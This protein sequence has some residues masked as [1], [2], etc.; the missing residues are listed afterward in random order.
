[1]AVAS[2]TSGTDAE[3]REREDFGRIVVSTVAFLAG[4]APVVLLGFN[5][6]G[7][8]VEVLAGYGV[9]LWWVLAVGFGT[10]ALPRPAPTTGGWL[11]LLS[12]LGLAAFGALSLT[13]SA[14]PERGLTE[15]SRMVVAG[16]SVLLGMSA[17]RAG[18]A[19]SLAGGVLAGLGVIVTAAVLARLQPDLFPGANQTAEFLGSDKR[20]SWPLNYW[21]ALGACAAVTISLAVPLA[22]R[23]RSVVGSALAVAPIPLAALLLVFALSRGGIVAAVLGLASAVLLVSPRPVL[24]RTMIAP[25]IGSVAVLLAATRRDPLMDAVGGSAQESAGSEVLT[26]AIVAVLG[27]AAVQAAFRLADNARWTPSIPRSS[28]RVGGRIIAGLVVLA[29]VVGLAAG[30]P[31]RVDDAWQEFKTPSVGATVDD[32]DGTGR[33][34]SASS[35]QRYQMWDASTRAFRD[36]PAQGLGLGS[37][38]SY[39]AQNRGELGFVRNAHSEVFELLAELGVLG[40]ALFLVILLA[41]ILA[42]VRTAAGRRLHRSDVVLVGP[43]IVAFAVGVAI[44]WNWQIGA[45]MVAGTALVG[46]AL[47]R[48]VTG[49]RRLG[50][51]APPRRPRFRVPLPPSVRAVLAPT[52]AGVVGLVAIGVLATALVAPRAVEASRDAAAAGQLDRAQTEA[53][54]AERAISFAASPALQRALVAERAGR[55]DQAAEAARTA[56]RRSPGTWE[57]WFVLARVQVAR[58]RPRSAVAAFRR[59]RELNPR[60]PGVRP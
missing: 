22:A 17:R 35:S 15:V 20:S 59:A 12:V 52:A 51:A 50:A 3:R 58:N 33:L 23:S 49:R 37:W 34:A 54:G 16:G 47:S 26:V 31:G 19:R 6:G 27:V 29:I 46:V 11:L 5:Q 48:S 13:W 24:L 25:A 39:W 30:A 42:G 45:Y 9:M 28:R 40:A 32:D 7:F 21:N 14:E 10:G 53:E 2:T 36:D 18:R 4:F 44:D 60:I 41:P 56:A 57:P 38:Q 43:A 8:P 55:L 1:M